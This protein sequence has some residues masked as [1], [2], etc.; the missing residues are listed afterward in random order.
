MKTVKL[1]IAV[2]FTMAVSIGVKA[3]EKYEYASVKLV[4]T[5]MGQKGYVAVS[6]ENKYEEIEVKVT[7]GILP[8]NLS[9]AIEVVNKMSLQGWE[10]YNTT[11]YA[12]PNYCV[13]YFLRKKKN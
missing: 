7:Q 3:Q 11:G 12:S 2:I 4:A 10:V 6:Q 9:P 13:H 5:G 8:D 1:L